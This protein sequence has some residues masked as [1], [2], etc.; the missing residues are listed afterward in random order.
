MQDKSDLIINQLATN[1]A[2]K[3]A[4]LEA[5]KAMLQVELN[6]VQQEN[7]SLKQQLEELRKDDKDVTSK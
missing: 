1:Y 7:Q 6:L 3:T 2:N 5:D 4:I